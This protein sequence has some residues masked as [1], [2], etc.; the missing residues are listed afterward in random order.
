MWAVRGGGKSARAV[1]GGGKS[2]WA[3]SVGGEQAEG[4]RYKGAERVG[5]GDECV[6]ENKCKSGGHMR[7]CG[8]CVGGA[9]GWCER[10]QVYAVNKQCVGGAVCGVA[11][12]GV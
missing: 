1:R 6:V 2:V 8:E 5:S 7:G 10:W 12:S 3:V 9:V 11:W 4:E